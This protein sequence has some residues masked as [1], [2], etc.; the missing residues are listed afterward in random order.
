MQNVIG[1]QLE[2]GDVVQSFGADWCD[3]HQNQKLGG[4]L[5]KAL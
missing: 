1:A 3:G 2:H 4:R 5:G